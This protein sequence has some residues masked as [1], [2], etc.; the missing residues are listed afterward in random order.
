[1]QQ[2]LFHVLLDDRKLGPYDR[3]TI[4]G[5]R[6]RKALTSE[7]VLVDADGLQLTVRDLIG[8][9]PR[10]NDFSPNRTSGYSIVQARYPAS[11]TSVEGRGIAIP[12]FKG[13]VEARVQADVLRIAGRYRKG[14]GWKE[15]RV[16]LPLQDIVHARVN[17]T[18][19]ELGLRAGEGR[20]PQRVRLELFT[21]EVAGEFLDWLPQATPWPEP[22]AGAQAAALPADRPWLGTHHMLWVAMASA[23]LVVFIIIGVLLA[24]RLY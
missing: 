19:V 7:D 9:Q 23:T 4:V 10:A 6:I 21:P 14:F 20:P 18:E 16:K 3:R 2:P 17:G 15:D 5:M 11:L 22:V 8:R 1:V 24:R 13:E 12:A